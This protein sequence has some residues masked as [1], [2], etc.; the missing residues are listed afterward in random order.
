MLPVNPIKLHQK[1]SPLVI[2][3]NATKFAKGS[4][5]FFGGG[6][7]FGSYMKIWWFTMLILLIWSH[8]TCWR[9]WW[10][11]GGGPRHGANLLAWR[12]YHAWLPPL[13]AL[14]LGHFLWPWCGECYHL[15]EHRG[16]GHPNDWSSAREV[17]HMFGWFWRNLEEKQLEKLASAESVLQSATQNWRTKRRRRRIT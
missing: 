4:R 5:R 15:R 7:F 10:T 8:N 3:Q 1:L 12:H 16:G 17:L 9:R 6:N 14:C 13:T 2:S 11:C